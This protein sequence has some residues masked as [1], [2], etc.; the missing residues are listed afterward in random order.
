MAN[1]CK[2]YTRS[3]FAVNTLYIQ[4]VPEIHGR[5]DRHD[6][7]QTRCYPKVRN[8]CP[9]VPRSRLRGTGVRSAKHFLV[10]CKR[11]SLRRG[12][13]KDQRAGGFPSAAEFKGAACG[14]CPVVHFLE[15]RQETGDAGKRTPLIVRPQEGHATGADVVDPRPVVPGRILPPDP[16][17]RIGPSE[18]AGLWTNAHRVL[19]V[20]DL[21]FSVLSFR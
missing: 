20:A 1:A 2:E 6:K 10:G 3:V 8:A 11:R 15:V 17:G 18:G 7:Q 4:S 16:D 12:N 9:A 14:P 19:G 13:K 21:Y 5:C